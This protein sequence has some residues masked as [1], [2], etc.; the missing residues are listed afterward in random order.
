[1]QCYFFGDAKPLYCKG[2]FVSNS[3]DDDLLIEWN[4]INKDNAEQGFV[5]AAFQ[6]MTETSSLIGKFSTQLLAGTG[7][8]GALFITQVNSI[9]PFL[10]SQG[11]KVCLVILVISAIFG[12][13]AKYHSLNC[14]IQ[15]NMQSKLRM[16]IKPVLEKHEKDEADIQEYAIQE[17]IELETDINLFKI[18][19]EFVKPFPFWVKWLVVRRAVKT[20][21]DRQAG[22]HVAVKSY[23]SQT[24]W[25]FLQ[26]CAFIAF[27]LSATWYANAI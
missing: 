18:M 6:S 16:L 21:V 10:S 1:M 19:T 8:T 12:F 24:H 3:K 15:N 25:T 4:Q 22:F 11:F 26:T 9:L 2:G 27:M 14:E 20:P 5:S 13:I 7:A 17:G 23:V